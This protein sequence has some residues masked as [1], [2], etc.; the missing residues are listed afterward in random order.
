MHKW[1]ILTL[2]ISMNS[3]A[4]EMPAHLEGMLKKS[5]E[6]F[7]IYNDKTAEEIIDGQYDES[8]FYL[9]EQI[10]QITGLDVVF[11]REEIKNYRFKLVVLISEM[12]SP[13]QMES[14][15]K[16]AKSFELN[17]RR[18]AK[19]FEVGLEYKLGKIS[20][21]NINSRLSAK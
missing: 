14:I 21:A 4:Q 20:R 2:F 9:F 6:Y 10:D 15:I 12:F 5:Q 18:V 7:E 8:E 1:L 17:R 13:F 19:Y 11:N 16:V 3:F